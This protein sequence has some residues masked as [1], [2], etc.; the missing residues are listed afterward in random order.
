[1][2]FKQEIQGSALDIDA[3]VAGLEHEASRTHLLVNGKA[4]HGI[5]RL[6]SVGAMALSLRQC[7]KPGEKYEIDFHDVVG[8]KLVFELYE[9]GVLDPTQRKDSVRF[10]GKVERFGDMSGEGMTLR[11]SIIRVFDFVEES[12]ELRSVEPGREVAGA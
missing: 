2:N 4:V 8:E 7:L 11:R 3:E 9:D 6:V 12:H 5:E 1:V 10:N